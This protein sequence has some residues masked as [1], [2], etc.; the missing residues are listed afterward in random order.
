MDWSS[1][2]QFG[3]LMAATSGALTHAELE[4]DLAELASAVFERH[5]EAEITFCIDVA[6]G[7]VA[8]PGGDCVSHIMTVPW[9]ADRLAQGESAEQ[10]F[11][12]TSQLL[13]AAIGSDKLVFI[14]PEWP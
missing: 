7:E 11:S 9:F 8:A 2:D 4:T 13:T 14:V 6:Y 1:T 3:N 10:I 12:E 5:P